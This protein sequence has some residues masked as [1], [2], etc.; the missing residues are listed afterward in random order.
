MKNSDTSCNKQATFNTEMT[1]H[2]IFKKPKTMFTEY[3]FLILL[4]V[5]TVACV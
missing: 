3:P 4:S 1:S 2:L 5:R